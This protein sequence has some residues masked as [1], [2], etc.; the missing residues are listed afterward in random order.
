MMSE[1]NPEL[2]SSGSAGRE[3]TSVDEGFGSVF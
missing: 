3:D 1:V 2:V